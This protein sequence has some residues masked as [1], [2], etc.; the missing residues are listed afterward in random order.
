MATVLANA[1][2]A[3]ASLADMRIDK[4]LVA[5]IAPAGT[6]ASVSI[7]LAGALLVPGFVDGHIHLDKTLLGLPFQPHRS[8]DTVAERIARANPLLGTPIIESTGTGAGMKLF[9]AGVGEKFP[10]VENASR[11]MKASEAKLCQQ[12]GVTAITEIQVG[13]DGISFLP[14]LLGQRGQRRHDLLYWEFPAYGGQ[15]AVIAGDWKAVR[16][17]LA[18]RVVKTE[19][20]NLTDDPNEA[21]DVAAKHP[22]VVSRLEAVMKEQHAP[23]KDF[24]LP[25][26]DAAAKK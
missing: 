9:C 24:P 18:K 17:N 11:R 16:Q 22:D 13:I 7:D 23:S 14:T 15:Q 3:D 6:L 12:N 19:L 1:L 10:D 5:A 2:L 4:G 26:I 20:Y 8:G 21:T 25:A